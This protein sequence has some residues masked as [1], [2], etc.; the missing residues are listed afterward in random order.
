MIYF[1]VKE[2]I[3]KKNNTKTTLDSIHT[4]KINTM[5]EQQKSLS[6][7]EN[8][9]SILKNKY[10]S[11]NNISICNND[12]LKIYYDLQN[13]ISTLE[14]NINNIKNNTEEINYLLQTGNLIFE[15]YNEKPTN[16][17]NSSY[18]SNKKSLSPSSSSILYLFNKKSTDNNCNNSTNNCNNS[19]NNNCNNFT[20]NNCNNSTN[21]N[22]NN[23]T[24]NN[25][26]NNCND[27]D[28]DD[29]I[30]SKASILDKYLSTVNKNH[31]NKVQT[32]NKDYCEL[33]NNILIVNFVEGHSYCKEC[34]ELY[35]IIIDTERPSYKEPPSEYNYFSYKRMNHF[36]EWL[37]QFQ[38]KESTDIPNE[39]IDNIIIELK[40]Q[41]I[42]NMATITHKKIREILKKLKLNKYYEHISYIINKINGIPP[43]IINP[44]IEEKLRSMFRDIQI[45]FLKH[46]PST[47]KNFL[48]YSYCLNKFFQLLDMDDYVKK[49][50]LL[51]SR[52]KLFAQDQIWKA[53]CKELK[54]EF[55]KSL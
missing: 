19:T 1:N 38:S 13:Q 27:N 47:R 49:F 6:T 9:L 33:C 42:T 40:K 41:R 54:W 50:P 39:I 31:K 14:T 36:S 12:E 18:S 43:P 16:N 44:E 29:T 37:A 52:E 5:K 4:K 46:C 48:S 30:L 55:H 28:N 26:N 20:N 22:C 17:I 32:Y 25:C 11:Y 45:P 3:R 35:Y 10:N 8:K 21:N 7:L 15:Y 24:N 23:S 34:G 2:K 53:I 51:K